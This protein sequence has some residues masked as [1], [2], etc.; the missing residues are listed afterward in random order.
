MADSAELVNP[1]EPCHPRIYTRL[2]PID[3]VELET[4]LG[5]YL[6]T[7]RQRTLGARVVRKYSYIAISLKC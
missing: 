1:S 3:M 7:L 2:Q 4:P 6:T 5:I